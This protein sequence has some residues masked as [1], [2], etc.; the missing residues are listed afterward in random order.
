MLDKYNQ[1]DIIWN[2]DVRIRGWGMERRK[3][4]WQWASE[5]VSAGFSMTVKQCMSPGTTCSPSFAAVAGATWTPGPFLF[6]NY[7]K[8]V[9]K[10]QSQQT[11]A[12]NMEPLVIKETCETILV[13]VRFS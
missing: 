7:R 6:F 2:S 11:R 12:Q 8:W 13:S 3:G 5:E 4:C 1:Y 10:N 9:F